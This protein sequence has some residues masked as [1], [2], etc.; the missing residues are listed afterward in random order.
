MSTFELHYPY[1]EGFKHA[2]ISNALTDLENQY[3]KIMFSFS[4]L[5]VTEL[6]QIL[7]V[8]S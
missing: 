7:G 6:Y 1:P 3:F 8:S 2:N 5:A 4:V